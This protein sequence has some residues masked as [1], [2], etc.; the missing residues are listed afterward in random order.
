[1]QEGL[2]CRRLLMLLMW[3]WVCRCRPACPECGQARISLKVQGAR[4]WEGAF[5][6]TS[7]PTC[8]HQMSCMLITLS[9]GGET[10]CISAIVWLALIEGHPLKSIRHALF[11]DCMLRCSRH[12]GIQSVIPT[13]GGM[14][15]EVEMAQR[16][17]CCLGSIQ[18][19]AQHKMHCQL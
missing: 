11:L 16:I 8:I 17:S 3:E 18:E 7:A 4:V 5:I 6:G 12:A 13:L 1:M 9:V 19:S 10:S 2:S 15:P 14:P